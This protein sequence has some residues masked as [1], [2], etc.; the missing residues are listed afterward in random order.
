MSAALSL[1]RVA[2][3]SVA[4][5][6]WLIS[7]AVHAGVLI[8]AMPL[9]ASLGDVPVQPAPLQVPI[10]WV[11]APEIVEPAVAVPVPR[12]EPEAVTRPAPAQ[13]SRAAPPVEAPRPAP[14]AV[15]TPQPAS[16]PAPAHAPASPVVPARDE[17]LP[18]PRIAVPRDAVVVA[19]PEAGPAAAPS[20]PEP[21]RSAPAQ[22]A[23]GDTTSI[24]PAARAADAA[25]RPAPADAALSRPS[26]RDAW[27][28]DLEALLATNKR[29]PRQAR[30]M[31]QQGVVTVHA[32]F[33]ADGELLRC[34][35]AASSGFRALDEAALELVRLAA[36]Q[37]RV[38]QAP[39]RVAEVHV[40]ISY[41]L[42]G[43]GT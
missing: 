11:A 9:V 33:A 5:R 28:A 36:G 29:Y 12:F 19:V 23:T 42:D 31:G 14:K 35:V 34:E 3:G 13:V 6:D 22:P 20:T 18:D 40:P 21:A 43:R 25:Q 8:A 16:R 1:G 7:L 41:E 24:A 37:L 10:R 4:P 30:R 27:R 32:R 38:N 15:P 26:A 17:P 39:G 2:P